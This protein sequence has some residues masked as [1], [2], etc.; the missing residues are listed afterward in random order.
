MPR[1]KPGQPTAPHAFQALRIHV[2]QELDELEHAL[3]ACVYLLKPGG[4]LA[5]GF[6][7]LE[8]R[9]V[10]QFM[11]GMSGRKAA[12]PGIVLIQRLTVHLYLHLLLV[13]QF[14]PAVQRRKRIRGSFS[15]T[16]WQGAQTAS[17]TTPTWGV[18]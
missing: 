8:D 12:R 1:P 11:A 2:N 13:N 9:I 6:H 5:V 15:K 10:K 14:C 4:I 3:A 17:D 16:A 7:S 18:S